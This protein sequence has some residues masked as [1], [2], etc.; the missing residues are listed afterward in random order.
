MTIDYGQHTLRLNRL[1]DARM[2]RAFERFKEFAD[3][4][5]SDIDSINTTISGLTAGVSTYSLDINGNETSTI[6]SPT[7]EGEMLFVAINKITSAGTYTINADFYNPGVAAYTVAAG[8]TAA[9]D[10]LFCAAAY[11][12]DTL[13]WWILHNRNWILST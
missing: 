4:T 9:G 13:S 10:Y 2:R 11:Y 6:G 12:A 8:G 5:K 3:T 7:T 1:Y